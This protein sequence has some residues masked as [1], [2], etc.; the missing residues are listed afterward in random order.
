MHNRKFLRF[1]H[2]SGCDG[3]LVQGK[4]VSSPHRVRK[5]G[6]IMKLH[7]SNRLKMTMFYDLSRESCSNHPLSTNCSSQKSNQN[8][9]SA[10]CI[11]TFTPFPGDMVKV[12]ALGILPAISKDSILSYLCNILTITKLASVSA[13]CS[14]P[15][16]ASSLHGFCPIL[17]LRP[18]HILGPPEN[19]INSH[20]NFLP[21]HLADLNPSASWP[22]ISFLLCIT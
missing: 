3:S 6:V 7:L 13:Y 22:Q 10:L 5:S 16:L 17:C 4:R 12:S 11:L 18:I 14:V 9:E 19:P 20:P 15:Q 2:R 21:S 8:H 1:C